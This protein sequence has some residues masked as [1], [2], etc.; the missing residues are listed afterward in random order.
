MEIK[1]EKEII[2]FWPKNTKEEVRVEDMRNLF[3][4]SGYKTDR[5]WGDEQKK[6]KRP[7]GIRVYLTHEK[8]HKKGFEVYQV[9]FDK[10]VKQWHYTVRFDQL[11]WINVN[12]SSFP[13]SEVARYYNVSNLPCNY[14]IDKSMVTILGKNL[15]SNELDKKLSELL[16]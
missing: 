2:V 7:L 8:Y 14:L 15:T 1:N 13:N 9:S 4:D 12:D 3:E 11:P 6:E 16:N 10:S 5:V